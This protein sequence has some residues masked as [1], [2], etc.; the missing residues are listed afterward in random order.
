[1]GFGSASRRGSR[2]GRMVCWGCPRSR[3]RRIWR[4]PSDR[5]SRPRRTASRRKPARGGDRPCLSPRPAR[6]RLRARLRR[7]RSLHG[8]HLARSQAV[9][10]RPSAAPPVDHAFCRACFRRGDRR[11]AAIRRALRRDGL[12]PLSADVGA[13]RL[14][15]RAHR[16]VR[17]QRHALLLRFR[18][19]LD[20]AGRAAPV[21]S[22]AGGVRARAALFRAKR[23]R[24]PR[25]ANSGSSSGLASAWPACRNIPARSPRSGF[26][27]CSRSRHRSAAGFA[28]RRPMSR[29]CLPG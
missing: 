20:H 5:G 22:R 17:S 6:L 28:T 13:V 26:S 8:S 1:M 12:A 2:R 27:P 18:R 7:R 10:F 9:L 11:A 21:R 24:G 14:P 4:E 25:L 29:R 3:R 15:G 23:G 19:D 16:F